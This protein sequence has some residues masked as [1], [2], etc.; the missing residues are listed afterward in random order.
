[1]YAGVELTLHATLDGGQRPVHWSSR[2]KRNLT[3]YD[4]LD[5]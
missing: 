2:S 3:N 4:G 1:M 5:I